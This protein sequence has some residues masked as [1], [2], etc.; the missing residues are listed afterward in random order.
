MHEE[1]QVFLIRWFGKRGVDHWF[2]VDT[3]Y[4]LMYDSEELYSIS[5]PEEAFILCT[6]GRSKTSMTGVIEIV[7]VLIKL[8]V[9]KSHNQTAENKGKANFNVVFHHW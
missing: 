3:R 4:G 5:L 7:D 2:S 9:V 6:G 1:I 8:V